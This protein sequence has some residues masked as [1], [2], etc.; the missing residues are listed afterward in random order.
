MVQKRNNL[1]SEI[2]LLLLRGGSHLRGMARALGVPHATV[3]RRLGGLAQEHVVD[4]RQEGRNKVFF[5]RGGLEAR[6]YVHSAERHKLLMLLKTYP[7]L[8][9]IIDDVLKTAG[10]RLVVLFGSYARFEAKGGSDIDIYVETDDVRVKRAVEAVHSKVRAKIGAFDRS[11]MLIREIIKSHV[12][13]RVVEEFHE[14]AGVLGE[15]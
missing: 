14:K 2:V 5:L 9:V 15:A 6:N 8:G 1:E 12:I 13:L 3:L 11:S 4:Y 7:E 10:E